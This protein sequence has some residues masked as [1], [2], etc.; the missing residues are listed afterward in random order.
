MKRRYLAPYLHSDDFDDATYVLLD[1]DEQD[2]R[3]VAAAR[4]SLKKLL[5]EVNGYGNIDI[6]PTADFPLVLT[7]LP[8][9]LREIEERIFTGEVLPVEIDPK[10]IP[11]HLLRKM[12]T[13]GWRVFKDAVYFIAYPKHYDGFWESND[14]EEFFDQRD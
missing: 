14:L 12:T 6:H 1:I 4:S 8:E 3:T 2:I 13:P 5:N 10:Q 7:E 9:E 11:K